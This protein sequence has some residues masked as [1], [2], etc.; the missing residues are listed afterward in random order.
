MQFMRGDNLE[1][2]SKFKSKSIDLIYADPPFFTNKQS[3][4]IWHNGAE[5][6]AFEDRWKG[7]N[8]SARFRFFHVLFRLLSLCFQRI[9]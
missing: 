4:I 7:G 2:M 6:R 5:K 8:G 9:S 1:I 3:E